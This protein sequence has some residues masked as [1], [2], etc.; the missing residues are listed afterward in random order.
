M[1]GMTQCKE[2]AIGTR[3][4]QTKL[5]VSV[6]SFELILKNKKGA[7]IHTHLFLL[8]CISPH[9]FWPPNTQNPKQW[10]KGIAYDRK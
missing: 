2:N 10:E 7:S 9:F 3:I 6:V 8:T 4:N 1:S 5:H